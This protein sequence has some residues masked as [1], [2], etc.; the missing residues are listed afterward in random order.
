MKKA[1]VVVGVC[2]ALVVGG[3]QSIGR[4]LD[5]AQELQEASTELAATSVEVRSKLLAQLTLGQITIEEFVKASAD[6][7]SA[8]IETAGEIKAAGVAE[9]AKLRQSVKTEIVANIPG[10]IDAGITSAVTGQGPIGVLL[11]M[12]AS[13]AVGAA[14]TAQVRKRQD[15]RNLAIKV[16]AQEIATAAAEELSVKRDESRKSQGH[17]PHNGIS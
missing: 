15:K 4:G 17:K 8:V 16:Q 2:V 12:L 5:R 13:L 6:I 10:A 1:V 9:L 7:D 11:S 14:G 3:C